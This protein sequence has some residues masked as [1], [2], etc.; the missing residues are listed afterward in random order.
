MTKIAVT[1]AAATA[2]GLR[3]QWD[4]QFI[5]RLPFNRWIFI[6][7]G[8]SRPAVQSLQINPRRRLSLGYI[9]RRTTY[10]ERPLYRARAYT[11]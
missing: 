3:R 7:S 1:A 2:A 5:Y 11:H 10:K 6:N 9:W 4:T 8:T